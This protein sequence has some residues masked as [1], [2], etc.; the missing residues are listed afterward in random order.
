MNAPSFADLTHEFRDLEYW[1]NPQGVEIR[2]DR[3]KFLYIPDYAEH[4]MMSAVAKQ[5]FDYQRQHAGTERQIT[6][7][8]MIAMGALLPGVLLHDYITH[9]ATQDMPPV[10]FGTFGVKYY[11]GPGQPLEKPEIVQRLSIDVHGET[12]AIVEDLADLGGTARFVRHLLVTEYGA[13]DAI[14]IAPY[15]KTS[16]ILE[17]IEVLW[18]GKVPADTWIITPR[19]RVETMMKRV[20]YW[21]KQGASRDECIANLFTIGYPHYMIDDWFDVAWA[22]E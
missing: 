20:P 12:V 13:R 5:V 4:M 18:F 16:A 22:R 3:L 17:D 6:K 15:I 7:M 21:R 10:E 8:V 2:K 9:G 14:L 11:H 19:E 1:K